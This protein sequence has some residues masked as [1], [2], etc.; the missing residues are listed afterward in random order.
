MKYQYT[1]YRQVEVGHHFLY[2]V[3]A[4][5]WLQDEPQCLKMT[6]NKLR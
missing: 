2:K 3:Q 1:K 5:S 4:P 6:K